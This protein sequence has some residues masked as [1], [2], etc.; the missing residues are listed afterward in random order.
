MKGHFLSNFHPYM[1][2]QRTKREGDFRRNLNCSEV[3]LFNELLVSLYHVVGALVRKMREGGYGI[4]VMCTRR[5]LS[6][7]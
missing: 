5:S 7:M 4:M 1:G 3:E 6:T 2:F